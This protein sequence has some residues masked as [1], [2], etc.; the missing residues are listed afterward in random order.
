MRELAVAADA[1]SQCDRSGESALVSNMPRVSLQHCHATASAACWTGN[2]CLYLVC[3]LL[4][5]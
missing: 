1:A 5:C 2:I 4:L 3:L